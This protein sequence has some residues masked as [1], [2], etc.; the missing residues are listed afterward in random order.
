MYLTAG[1]CK[2][3][4]HFQFLI[5]TRVTCPIHNSSAIHPSVSVKLFYFYVFILKATATRFFSPAYPPDPLLHFFSLYIHLPPCFISSQHSSSR[6]LLPTSHINLTPSSFC[7]SSLILLLMQSLIFH[8]ICWSYL[9]HLSNILWPN[10]NP[11][12]Q[13]RCMRPVSG[14]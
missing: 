4:H 7:I 2:S 6:H 13:W 14:H 8:Y 3:M 11:S 12:V 1:N 5:A 10:P 9:L